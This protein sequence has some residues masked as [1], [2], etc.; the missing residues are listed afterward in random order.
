MSRKSTNRKITEAAQHF[1]KKVK[2]WKAV[3]EMAKNTQSA[4]VPALTQNQQQVHYNCFLVEYLIHVRRNINKIGLFLEGGGVYLEGL[5]LS[6]EVC[7]SKFVRA[8]KKK[9]Y[10]NSSET[11]SPKCYTIV[12]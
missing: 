6:R 7:N 8:D 1:Q 12:L 2:S 3:I 4:E 11:I 9:L 10:Q 5:L